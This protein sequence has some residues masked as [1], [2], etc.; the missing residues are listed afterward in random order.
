MKMLD[1]DWSHFEKQCSCEWTEI[2]DRM[3]GKRTHTKT[4]KHIESSEHNPK[5][6]GDKV[7]LSLFF[8]VF[9][10]CKVIVTIMLYILLTSKNLFEIASIVCYQMAPK[11]L[12]TIIYI[13]TCIFKKE[14]I[15]GGKSAFSV[16][17]RIACLK[18]QLQKLST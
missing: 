5:I 3:V 15:M 18:F 17:D 4:L 2:F 14:N 11:Y 7:M 1:S 8:S 9:D 6:M 13:L 16:I 12:F 10:E